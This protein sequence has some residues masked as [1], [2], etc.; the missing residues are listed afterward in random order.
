MY[1]A[2]KPF[3]CLRVAAE[4]IIYFH[5]GYTRTRYGIHSPYTPLLDKQDEELVPTC[6]PRDAESVS[7][8]GVSLEALAGIV[9][10]EINAAVTPMHSQL[11]SLQVTLGARM[12]QVEN[13]LHKHDLQIQKFEQYM[14]DT[15]DQRFSN[16]VAQDVEK[17]ITR[18]PNPD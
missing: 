14:A 15:M 10:Q 17:T 9:R 8:N 16:N 11:S 6:P 13:V 7:G 3:V 4:L 2:T 1:H 5:C 18:P 12:D